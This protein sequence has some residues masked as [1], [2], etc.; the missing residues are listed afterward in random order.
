MIS[1]FIGRWRLPALAALLVAI[2]VGP[3]RHAGAAE[4]GQ[5]IFED[6]CAACHTIGGGK[7]VGPDLA[8]VTTRRDEDWLI[9][10]IKE[11]DVLIAEND[12]I[13]IQLLQESEDVPMPPPD[14]NDEQIAAVIEYLKSTVQ[15]TTV[16]VGLPFQYVP[17]LLISL[18]VLAGLTLLGF[19][20]GRKKVDVR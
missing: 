5:E 13:A 8:G 16:A 2:W 20:A 3:I 10:Q 14:L 18:V 6:L 12:P 9:R 17:T 19:I 7:T 11:P 4:N 15:Q 1:C